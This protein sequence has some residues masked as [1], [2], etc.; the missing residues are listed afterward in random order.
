MTVI[1][2]NSITGVTSITAQGDALTLHSS[3]G[4]LLNELQTNI[5]ASSGVSTVANLNVIG[6]SV[7]IG[8]DTIS[9]KVQIDTTS[10]SRALTVNAPTNGTY[11]TF[12]T[13]DTPYADIGSEAGAVGSGT[14]DLLVLNARS[15]RD[16]AF[17][18]NSAERLRITSTGSV[19]INTTS[20]GAKLHVYGNSASQ[21]VTLT[22][23]ATITPDFSTGNNFTVTLGD[24][25]TLANPT[26]TTVGQSGVLYIVQDGTGSRT[27][28]VGT[29]WHFP[30]GTAPTL[31]TT[32]NAV[33]V[34]AFS[35]RSSTSVVANAILDVKVTA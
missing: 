26:N 23:G 25:R 2:P 22:D 32:A 11:I 28:G 3:D 30:A 27:L 19:G 1:R 5:N 35:V 29:H 16:L 20:P 6:G 12:E 4:T 31:T 15:T 14:N 8:T 9:G 7:G 10:G 17:R 18:T 24:N 13:N 34:F 33:D 21:I